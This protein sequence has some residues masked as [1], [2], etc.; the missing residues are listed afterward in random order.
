[1]SIIAVAL[2][3]FLSR[4]LA[5]GLSFVVACHLI[6]RLAFRMSLVSCGMFFSLACFH[7][8]PEAYEHGLS[9]RQIGVVFAIAL[10]FF[11]ALDRLLSGPGGHVHQLP[12]VRKIPALLGGGV[13]YE[14]DPCLFRESRSTPLFVGA[15]S[16]NF[17]DGLLVAAAFSDGTATGLFITAAIFAHEVPQLVS[18]IVLLTQMGLSRQKVLSG[19]FCLALVPV[20]GSV[21]GG[22]LFEVAESLT[23]Y[24]MLVSAASFL[25]VVY[26]ILP[27]ILSNRT[28]KSKIQTAG[29]FGLGVLISLF[30][31]VINMAFGHVC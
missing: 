1:M 14:V 18:Q 20:V 2:I 23:P 21:F 31:I 8:L 12:K 26:L 5:L 11:I 6:G 19:C 30:L 22:L 13:R 15:A 4:L 3:N 25:F 24:A 29:W 28:L 9:L 7:L 27:P 10:L 17:V 16:H